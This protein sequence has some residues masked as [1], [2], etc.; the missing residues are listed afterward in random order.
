MVAGAKEGTQTFAV[1]A[2]R[3]WAQPRLRSLALYVFVVLLVAVASSL[4]NADEA[5]LARLER[6]AF[7]MQ[8]EYLREQ[9]YALAPDGKALRYREAGM[10]FQANKPKIFR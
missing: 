8:M 1:L 2:R 6:G 4:P 7:D 9:T 10:R 3:A 5:P